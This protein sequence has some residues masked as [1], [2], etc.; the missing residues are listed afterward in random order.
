MELDALRHG[1]FAQLGEAIADWEEMTEKLAT[2]REDARSGLKARADKANWAGVNAQ[3]GREFI[4]KTAKEFADAHVQADSITKILKD[5]HDELLGYRDQLNETLG[6]DPYK[7]CA[8]IDTGHGRFSVTGNPRPDWAT[9]PSGDPSPVSQQ[10]V[11]DLRDEIQRI[12]GEATESDST[13]AR[14]RHPGC[15]SISPRT[16]SPAPTTRTGTTLPGRSRT[17]TGWRTCSPR[18]PTR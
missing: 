9:G 2:L 14:P 12:L 15:S 13:A 4:G 1:R 6:R 16:D 18:T 11:D 17:P 8:V 5:T 3:V 10:V 7:Y